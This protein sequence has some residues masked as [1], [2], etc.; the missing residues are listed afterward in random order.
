MT[1]LR[2]PIMIVT[3][4]AHVFAARDSRIRLRAT[5]SKRFIEI[6]A[7]RAARAHDDARARADHSQKPSA[8]PLSFGPPDPNTSTQ[9][10]KPLQSLSWPRRH[11]F[12]Q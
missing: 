11:H 8:V 6:P 4:C 2:G 1:R 12:S 3:F 5:E 10:L 7:T 9:V